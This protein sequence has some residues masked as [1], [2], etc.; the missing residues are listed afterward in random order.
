[1]DF[2]QHCQKNCPHKVRIT[3]SV[4]GSLNFFKE[5]LN[6]LRMYGN[7]YSMAIVLD[8]R[9]TATSL[10]GNWGLWATMII[11]AKLY[12]LGGITK[13]SIFCLACFYLEYL[14]KCSLYG[15]SMLL[16]HFWEVSS[17]GIAY[18][19]GMKPFQISIGFHA[20]WFSALAMPNRFSVSFSLY[21]TV[22]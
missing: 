16:L 12:A 9:S 6:S 13:S 17:R 14:G 10:T 15:I 18:R 20:W 19:Q 4:M 3:D 8:H 2:L 5:V 7:G 22:W 21:I 1:M 11:H